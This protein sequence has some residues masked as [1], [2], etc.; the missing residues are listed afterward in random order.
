MA[1]ELCS[2]QFQRYSMRRLD[3]GYMMP[4]PMVVGFEK[5]GNA[6]KPREEVWAVHESQ[7]WHG[8]LV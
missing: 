3:C 8:T 5:H 4:M 2:R 1:V 6:E 7:N